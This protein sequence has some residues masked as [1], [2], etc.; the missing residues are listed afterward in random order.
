MKPIVQ[1]FEEIV[2]RVSDRVMPIIN[3]NDPNNIPFRTKIHYQH[4][5][6]SEIIATLKAMDETRQNQKE[7]FPLIWLEQDFRE[8]KGLGNA[9]NGTW[10]PLRIQIFAT[11]QANI[12]AARRYEDVFVPVLIPIYDALIDEIA[13]D[14]TFSVFKGSM[15]HDYIEHPF[16]G[17]EGLYGNTENKL[18]RPLD[19]IEIRNLIL[20]LRRGY[21]CENTQFLKNF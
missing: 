6:Q 11:T 10:R 2:E 12:K 17:K 19:C 1:I 16:Y 8:Q 9:T 4:G 13:K 21:E 15:A 3:A 20:P 5:H 14:G 18:N 7:K